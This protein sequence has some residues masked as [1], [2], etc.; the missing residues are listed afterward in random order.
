LKRKKERK[1]ERERERERGREL[2][3][4]DYFSVPE[5]KLLKIALENGSSWMY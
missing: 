4:N 1:R 2:V 3:H 5:F